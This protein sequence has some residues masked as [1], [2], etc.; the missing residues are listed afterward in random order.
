MIE[1]VPGDVWHGNLFDL[2]KWAVA[3]FSAMGGWAMV[4]WVYD[5]Y[6]LRLDRHAAQK[7]AQTSER[8]KVMASLDTRS[9]GYMDRLERS[10][11]RLV[12]ELDGLR[13]EAKK[14]LAQA[15]FERDVIYIV[16]QEQEDDCYHRRQAHISTIA[17]LNELIVLFARLAAGKLG[18]AEIAEGLSTG[19]ESEPPRL[20]DIRLHIREK[21]LAMKGAV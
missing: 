14:D 4:R 13:E 20:H 5:K 21:T 18:P 11:N 12:L 8:E 9:T 17:R 10:E 19:P 15:Q 1:A 16:L 2:L 6:W 7:V 3:P